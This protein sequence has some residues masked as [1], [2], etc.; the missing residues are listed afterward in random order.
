VWLYMYIGFVLCHIIG[1]QK[2]LC[3]DPICIYEL[4]EGT[5]CQSIQDHSGDLSSMYFDGPPNVRRSGVGYSVFGVVNESFHSSD[6]DHSFH[7]A[8]IIIKGRFKN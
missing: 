4:E 3:R 7:V 1:Q 2:N 5:P 8:M 6:D